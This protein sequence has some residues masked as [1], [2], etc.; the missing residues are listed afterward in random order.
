LFSRR[1]RLAGKKCSMDSEAERAATKVGGDSSSEIEM[2][3][4]RCQVWSR[5]SDE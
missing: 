4:G 5:I 3:K 1:P 2:Q